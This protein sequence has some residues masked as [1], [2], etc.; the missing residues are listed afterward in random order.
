MYQI[1]SCSCLINA[2]GKDLTGQ[3]FSRLTVLERTEER[4]GELVM[5]RCRC[6]CGNEKNAASSF[7]ISGSVRSCDCLAKEVCKSQ[8]VEGTKIHN[9]TTERLSSNNTSGIKGVYWE[10][11]AQNG[12]LG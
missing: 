7:L 5:W 2:R 9:L 8:G 12:G 3:V 10:K 1:K 4:I 6:E 11:G